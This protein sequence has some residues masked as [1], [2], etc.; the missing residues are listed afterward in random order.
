MLLRGPP[1]SFRRLD[2]CVIVFCHINM[3]FCCRTSRL[4]TLA[5][6]LSVIGTKSMITQTVA[7]SGPY[8]TDLRVEHAKRPLGL[9]TRQPRFS[10][11]MAV[12]RG[13]WTSARGFTQHSA[14]I[15]VWDSSGAAA[16]LSGELR[17][18]RSL[19][20]PYPENAAVLLP[21]QLYSWR[22]RVKNRPTP[23]PEMLTGKYAGEERVVQSIRSGQQ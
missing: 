11:A 10:W 13:L 7:V 19:L 9:D 5:Y 12:P 14:E 15:E 20:L 22:V 2:R 16:W 21:G 1:P 17:T 4:W 23:I 18:N 6:F 8:A 3:F